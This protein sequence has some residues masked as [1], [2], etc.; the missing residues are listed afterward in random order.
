MNEVKDKKNTRKRGNRGESNTPKCSRCEFSST[1]R[2]PRHGFGASARSGSFYQEGHF[3]NHPDCKRHLIFY[4]I[5]S[6]KACPLK[7]KRER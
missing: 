7:N 5:T 3:C 4:G 6:P 2:F 1:Q